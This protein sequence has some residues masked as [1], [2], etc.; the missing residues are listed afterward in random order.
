MTKLIADPLLTA[1]KI[2]IWILQAI[3]LLVAACILLGIAAMMLDVVDVRQQLIDQGVPERWFWLV[4]VG[5]AAI[6]A[7]LGLWFRFLQLLR[8]VIGSVGL[9]DPFAPE[10]GDRLSRMGWLVVGT[11]VLA[12]PLGLVAGFVARNIDSDGSRMMVD[13]DGGGG[14]L[15][16]VLTLF[17]LARVFRHGTAM[18]EE[19]EGTV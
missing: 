11:Y 16:L 7:I 3:V 9:G 6:A 12:L 5:F 8:Q 2:V 18:R 1:A 10:N 19:L 13:V 14:G 15:I 4:Y 17:I